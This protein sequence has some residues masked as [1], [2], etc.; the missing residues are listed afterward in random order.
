MGM[1]N[2]PNQNP[3]YQN[4]NY[5]N[6][7]YQNQGYQQPNYQ[8]PNYQQPNQLQAPENHLAKA[9]V[10]TILCWPFG[11]AG[12]INAAKV[13]NLWNSGRYEE[14]VAASQNAAKWA[15]ISLTLGIILWVIYFIYI[16]VAMVA[17]GL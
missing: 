11:I 17:L 16:F 10:G 5:Q 12:I 3:N 13:N 15:R 1:Y 6:Q 7:G 2:D 8:Q 9:I 4:P 14:A